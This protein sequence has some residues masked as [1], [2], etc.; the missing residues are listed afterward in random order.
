MKDTELAKI[1]CHQMARMS[2]ERGLKLGVLKEEDPVIIEQLIKELAGL[3]L[4]I[5][6][7][8]DE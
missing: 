6:G 7:I 5:N 2:I 4:K 8:F 3:Y 1:T